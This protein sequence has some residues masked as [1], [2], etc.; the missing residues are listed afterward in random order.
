V[1]PWWAAASLR[2]GGEACPVG[3]PDRPDAAQLEAT[4]AALR[5]LVEHALSEQERKLGLSPEAVED[6]RLTGEVL[7]ELLAPRSEEEGG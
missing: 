6:G 4:M 3:G 2:P 7:R 5:P 1:A